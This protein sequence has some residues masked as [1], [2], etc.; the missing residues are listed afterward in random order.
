MSHFGVV[1]GDKGTAAWA[2][3]VEHALGDGKPAQ[4]A[5]YTFFK[6]G[7]EY[8]VRNGLTGEIGYT[9]TN[10]VTVA[11]AILNAMGSG[12][13][14][15]KKATYPWTAELVT[16]TSQQSLV[17][18]KGVIL[19]PSNNMQ[20]LIR[21]AATHDH[22]SVENFELDGNSK[23]AHG[24]LIRGAHDKAIGNYIHGIDTS[25]DPIILDAAATG[26][27]TGNYCQDGRNGILLQ[28][29]SSYNL[30][31]DNDIYGSDSMGIYINNNSD[32]N[33]LH[34]NTIRNIGDDCINVANGAD[35]NIIDHN[36][37]VLATIGDGIVVGSNG[38]TVSYYNIISENK[39][40]SVSK[41]IYLYGAQRTQVHGNTIQ[42]TTN[43]IYE[44]D[45]SGAGGATVDHNNI[46]GND[47]A[48]GN[49]GKITVAGNNSLVKNNKGYNPIGKVA[50]SFDTTNDLIKLSGTGAV[51][52]STKT[53]T[54][55]N[56]DIYINSSD[57]GGADCDI[58]INDNLGNQIYP[59][60]GTVSTLNGV[61]VPIGYQI[62]WGT[63]SGAD[64]TVI[65][66]F[67]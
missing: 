8:K 51:P 56:S 49:T 48:H 64:P 57:S 42:N 38:G 53:Y 55:C 58:A 2:Q 36:T 10:A 25:H 14:L 37:L 13:L 4:A 23:N 66:C 29:T 60:T 26:E 35:G 12:T 46:L 39:I 6:D 1:S 27:I 17:A 61:F 18:E 19:Q 65:V 5:S 3:D 41:G 34:H 24:I 21:L 11:Q 54:V 50:T 20:S 32:Q 22:C 62:T 43:A 44:A 30:V 28:A 52:V 9:G 31:H 7:S 45:A 47:V 59:Q 63:F 16:A 67:C 15:F 33:Q 40:D